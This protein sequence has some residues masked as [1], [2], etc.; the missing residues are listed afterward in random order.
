M[1][2]VL[3]AILL[4][5][6][7]FSVANAQDAVEQV[8]RDRTKTGGA[9]TLEDIMA[10]QRGEKVDNSFRSNATGDPN[11]AAGMANQL[12]TLG[13]TSDPELWRS[14]RFWICQCHK[15]IQRAN[16]NSPGAGWWHALAD[17]S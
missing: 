13:G 1:F 6:S 14:L 8:P 5:L 9:Q 10:R 17:L 15:H 16:R 2:R 12:G 4:T 11:S 3:I 7:L